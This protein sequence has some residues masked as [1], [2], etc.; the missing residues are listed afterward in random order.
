MEVAAAENA[1]GQGQLEI[2][3]EKVVKSQ[4]RYAAVYDF[5]IICISK[6]LF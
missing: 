6:S 5:I 4:V 1:D 3:A 2:Y